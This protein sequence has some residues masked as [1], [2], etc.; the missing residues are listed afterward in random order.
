MAV[1]KLVDKLKRRIQH[2]RDGLQQTS[3]SKDLSFTGAVAAYPDRNDLHRYMHHHMGHLCPASV[4]AHRRYFSRGKRGFGEDALHAMWFALL[5]EFKPHRCLEIGV[6]RGQVV[7]LWGLISRE[8]GFACEIHGISPFSPAGDTVSTYLADLDYRQDV[9]ESN[10]HFNLSP[11]HLL[12]ALSTDN[13]ALEYIAAHQWDLVYIDGNHDLE[14]VLSDYRACR[15]ALAPG[16][17]LVL[18]DSSLNTDFKPPRYSFAGHPGPSTVMQDVAMRE[19]K[20]LGGVAHNNVF[21]NSR[22]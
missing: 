17:L 2:A 10:A 13:Q 18:D 9:I 21:Q 15:Q 8:V 6:Y 14:V 22:A 3:L 16:G 11:L 1:R 4:R 5:R 19:L 20:F 7:T 12:A